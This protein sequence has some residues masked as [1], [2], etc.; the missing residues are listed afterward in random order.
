[1]KHLIALPLAALLLTHCGK[2]ED[3]ETTK[4]GLEGDVKGSI[5]DVGTIIIDL[6][7]AI[8]P[9][10]GSLKLANDGL[11]RLFLIP[12]AFTGVAEQMTTLTKNVV[13]HIFGKAVCLDDDDSNDVAD[14]AEYGGIITGQISETA[15][16]FEIPGDDEESPSHVKYWANPA[17]SDY[18][19]GVELYWPAEGGGYV[20]AMQ[21]QLSKTGEKQG[22]GEFTFFPNFAGGDGP[23]A[24]VTKFSATDASKTM[25]VRLYSVSEGD[26][27]T[28]LGLSVT[29]TDGVISGSGTAIRPE[30]TADSGGLAPFQTKAEFAYVYTL[31][32]DATNN[33]GVEKLAGVPATAYADES[34]YFSAHGVDSSLRNFAL[35]LLRNNASPNLNCATSGQYIST[36]LPTNIC[37]TN[38]A[39]TDEQVLAGLVTFCTNNPN[40]SGICPIAGQ[41][42]R[43]A[44]PIYLD[45]NGYIGNEVYQ[46][47]T[48][49]AYTP[50][51]EALSNITVYTPTAFKAQ[52]KPVLPDAVET[53]E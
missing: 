27:P 10:S 30:Q 34:T 48:S 51:V 8:A 2:S 9:A 35:E 32:A 37:K 13:E 45:A 1:M 46:K 20:S 14:C 16:V 7:S 41:A 29:D 11:Q 22:K 28:G 25:D 39:V 36:A 31:A 42:S 3:E 43:W 17:G 53:V 24:I 4:S 15:T 44:N 26:G 5:P 19:V 23:D 12:V 21:M 18:D 47:P 33:I 49:A 6:P 38:T 50:L 52:T 40:D